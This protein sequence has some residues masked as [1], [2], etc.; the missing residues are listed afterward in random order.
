M[1]LLPAIMAV[2][3]VGGTLPTKI[4]PDTLFS[5]PNSTI[6]LLYTFWLMITLLE[7]LTSL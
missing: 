1:L 2:P 3:L 7:V 4:P 5:F 6:P